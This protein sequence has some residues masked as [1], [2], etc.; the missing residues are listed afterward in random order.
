MRVRVYHT[1]DRHVYICLSKFANAII[2]LDLGS[3]ELTE[4]PAEI[5]QLTNLQTLNL[6]GH[7]FGKDNKLTS[8]PSEIG[9]LN[10][11]TDLDLRSNNLS[12]EAKEEITQLLPNCDISF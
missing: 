7:R 2:Q 3:N 8:L 11:L 6:G 10:N 9:Q 5:G 1:F 4:L 12:D